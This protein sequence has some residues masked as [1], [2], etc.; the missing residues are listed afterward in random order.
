MQLVEEHNVAPKKIMVL[1]PYL[2]Q[3]N[4]LREKLQQSFDERKIFDKLHIGSVVTSQGYLNY[5]TT[6]AIHA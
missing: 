3:C 2:G 5:L 6:P 4:K 1:S